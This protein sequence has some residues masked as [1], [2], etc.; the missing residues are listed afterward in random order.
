MRGAKRLY[1]A[2]SD[3]A[4]R[5][6]MAESEE[7]AAVIRTTN[8]IQAVMANIEKRAPRFDD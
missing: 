4:D 7:E 1:N 2:Y 5:L 6:L 3:D 8:Q